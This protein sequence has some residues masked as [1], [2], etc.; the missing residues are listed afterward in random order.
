MYG[1][2][3]EIW[4]QLNSKEITQ[5]K[6]LLRTGSLTIDLTG[7]KSGFAVNIQKAVQLIEEQ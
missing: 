1:I 4:G 6:I 3:G 5:M 2:P 7:I